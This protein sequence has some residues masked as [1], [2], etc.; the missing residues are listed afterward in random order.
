MNLQSLFF[1]LAIVA[2]FVVLAIYLNWSLI[3]ILVIAF[4]GVIF[5]SGAIWLYI[6]SDP[7]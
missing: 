6:K 2:F 3:K 7:N 5:I 1:L 4:V